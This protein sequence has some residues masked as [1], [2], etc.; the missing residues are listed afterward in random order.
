MWYTFSVIFASTA[1]SPNDIW[2]TE[3]MYLLSLDFAQ[4]LDLESRLRGQHWVQYWNYTENHSHWIALHCG[5]CERFTSNRQISTIKAH[6]TIHLLTSWAQ[7]ANCNRGWGKLLGIRNHNFCTKYNPG[8]RLV[9]PIER[10]VRD[11]FSSRIWACENIGKYKDN[12]EKLSTDDTIVR[13]TALFHNSHSP[14]QTPAHIKARC[15][16]FHCGKLYAIF[17]HS[18]HS[19]VCNSG[20]VVHVNVSLKTQS[21]HLC[22]L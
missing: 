14:I 19:I 2:L 9:V 10:R 13:S 4:I 18:I 21:T 6:F 12:L 20:L 17:S 1:P 16:S 5:G 8:P 15:W 3:Q 7:R 22:W 11:W